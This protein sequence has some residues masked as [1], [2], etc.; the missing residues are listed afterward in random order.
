MDATQTPDSIGVSRSSNSNLDRNSEESSILPKPKTYLNQMEALVIL[1]EATADMERKHIQ[2]ARRVIAK[3]IEVLRQRYH[4]LHKRKLARARLREWRR[5]RDERATYICSVCKQERRY[6]E[7]PALGVS[8][9][10]ELVCGH[11][12]AQG[13]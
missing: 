12:I 1:Y 11:C 9:E 7:E 6:M 2:R 4:R 3:R 10:N 13:K 8:A 5:I